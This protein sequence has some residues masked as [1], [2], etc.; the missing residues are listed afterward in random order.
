LDSSTEAISHVLKPLPKQLG[1]KYGNKFPAIQKAVLGL[2][3]EVAA[4]TLMSGQALRVTVDG[5]DYDL[6]SDE[7]EVK[8]MAKEG[9]A[10]A[11]DGPYVAAL[12]TELTPDLVN[13]GLAREFVRRVQ[14]LRKQTGLDVADRIK[15]YV[16]A[17]PG[18]AQAIAAHQDYIT[19]ET[20]ALELVFSELPASIAARSE[21]GFDGENVT[22]GLTKVQR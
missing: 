5:Q 1:Q 6:L 12:V 21:D 14:D 20:L 3:S 17:T 2:D 18:L 4:R 13:E 10:V 11:E 7:I 16:N 19:T 8:A 22:Y 15:L 9:F